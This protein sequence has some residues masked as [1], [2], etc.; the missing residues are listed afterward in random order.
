MLKIK[1][2]PQP[3][4][5]PPPSPP[6]PAAALFMCQ[7]CITLALNASTSDTHS[8]S[9]DGMKYIYVLVFFKNSE[10]NNNLAP[11][12]QKQPLLPL[13]SWR[14]GRAST[15]IHGVV[16]MFTALFF[17]F[18]IHTYMFFKKQQQPHE[19]SYVA[20]HGHPSAMHVNTTQRC[21]FPIRGADCALWNPSYHCVFVSCSRGTISP[22]KKTETKKK[23]KKKL[24]EICGQRGA[25]ATNRAEKARIISWQE[26]FFFFFFFYI[27]FF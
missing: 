22:P 17:S 3:D 24:T 2:K 10:L 20:M 14:R 12:T 5:S 18:Y 19:P 11:T 25:Q 26:L 9:S 4:R 21:T 6:P 13:L 1:T 23:K 16:L 7:Y 8:A 27:L 15:T